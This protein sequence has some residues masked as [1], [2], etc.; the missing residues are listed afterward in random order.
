VRSLSPWGEG[1]HT[2][3]VNCFADG[4][5]NAHVILDS[6][7]SEDRGATR[8]PLDPPILHRIDLAE[9]PVPDRET[10]G[11]RGIQNGQYNGQHNGQHNGKHNGH[12]KANGAALVEYSPP[13]GLEFWD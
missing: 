5:T 10:Q 13:I 11:I 2:A 3:A 6:P 4:G 9:A 1:G 7:K 8:Q 12:H